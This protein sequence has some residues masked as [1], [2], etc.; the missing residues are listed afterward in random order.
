[1]PGRAP[2][3]MVSGV[4]EGGVRGVRKR[5]TKPPGHGMLEMA[6]RILPHPRSARFRRII[7]MLRG[8]PDRLPQYHPEASLWP[9]PSPARSGGRSG[10]A[11]S[12]LNR[13]GIAI[14]WHRLVRE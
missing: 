3:K 8:S 12:D 2:P 13:R 11:E 1:M 6:R 10:G 4:S 14:G 9:W 7:E 5:L